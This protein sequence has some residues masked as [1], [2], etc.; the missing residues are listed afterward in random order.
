MA[1]FDDLRITNIFY[2][3]K[4]E[5]VEFWKRLY[6]LEKMPSNDNRFTNMLN[7]L[8]QHRINNP[9]DWDDY[10]F[11]TDT[12]VNLMSCD[13]DKLLKFLLQ[14]VHPLVRRDK[15]EIRILIELYNKYLSN[16]GFNIVPDQH[17]SGFPIFKSVN[18]D[19]GNSLQTIVK[20]AKTKA[21]L[22]NHK[23]LYNQLDTLTNLASKNPELAI[24]QSKE[25]I[26]SFCKTILSDFKVPNIEVLDFPVLIKKVYKILNILPV[27]VSSH[28]KG[29][30][31]LKGILGSLYNL[32]IKIDELRNIYGTGHGKQRSYKGLSYRHAKL[33]TGSTFVLL[34]FLISVYD[35]KIQNR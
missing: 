28:N 19:E 16:D 8:Y 11:L 25:I 27:D 21:N 3:G 10:W 31:I 13:D 22:L 2:L 15:E 24:G 23:Y 33:V 5:E 20:D 26:E 34:T 30:E 35:E 12:R 17:I 32:P 7:D 14:T 1:L 9:M 29:A 4:L 18:L 6:N